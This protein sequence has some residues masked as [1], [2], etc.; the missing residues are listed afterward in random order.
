MDTPRKE[1]ER[2]RTQLYTQRDQWMP[3][4]QAISEHC[5]PYRGVFNNIEP[6]RGDRRDQKILNSTPCRAL[7]TMAS[8]LHS[9]MASPSSPW[10][11]LSTRDKGLAQRYDVRRWLD[12]VQRRMYS[13]FQGSNFYNALYSLYYEL[14]AFGVGAMHI[15]EDYQDVI[16]CR[17]FTVGEYALGTAADLRVDALYRTVWMTA[18]QM[19]RGFGE[20]IVSARIRDLVRNKPE[21]WVYCYHAIEH[22]DSRIQLP[23]T[24]NRAYR[25]IYWESSPDTEDKFLRVSGWNEQPFCAPRWETVGADVYGNGPGDMSIGDSK[26]LMRQ[27]EDKLSGLDRVVNPPLAIPGSRRGQDVNALPGGITYYDETAQAKPGSLYQINLPLSEL[28]QT[29]AATEE[30]INQTFFVDLFM[31]LAMS[32]LRDITAREVAERHEEKLLMIG[33]ALDNMQTELF[34]PSIGRTFAIMNRLTLAGGEPMIPTPPESLQG[35]EIQVEYVSILAQAQKMVG[36]TAIEQFASFVGGLA[37]VKPEV[38]DK[39]DADEAVDQYGDIIGVPAAIV[40]PDE[41][42]AKIRA[43]RVKE[44]A[45]AKAAE[46]AMVAAQ[47]AKT[48]SETDMSSNNALTALMGGGK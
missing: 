43:A 45:A 35:E 12:E 42:V 5:C 6:N 29:I 24:K 1:L 13:V 41:Q 9:G 26:M 23:E 14:G 7:R 3:R 37:G 16:R 38:I 40:V 33:P 46:S 30:D 4:Y 48:L 17:T 28:R 19:F 36:A 27:E 21:A 18:L 8:G 11:K 10:F 44:Q 39:L 2:R 20:D 47:G 22:N 34:D 31:M 15:S 32:D 25:D